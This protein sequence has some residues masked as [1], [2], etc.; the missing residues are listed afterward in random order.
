[1]TPTPEYALV[2]CSE[3]GPRHVAIV[4]VVSGDRIRL[5]KH[6]LRTE[7]DGLP[8]ARVEVLLEL[9]PLTRCRLP[10]YRAKS[11]WV[12]TSTVVRDRPAA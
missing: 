8:F 1:M 2:P 4:D 10:N 9:G 3:I 7:P 11:F 12:R 5:T 6:R